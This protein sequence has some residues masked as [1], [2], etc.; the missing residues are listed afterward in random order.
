MKEATNGTSILEGHQLQT[1]STPNVTFTS[2]K[3]QQLEQRTVRCQ[4]DREHTS[5]QRAD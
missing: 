2:Q 5:R 1:S 4:V 3:T